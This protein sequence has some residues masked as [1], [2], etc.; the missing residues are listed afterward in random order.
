M[1]QRES[2]ELQRERTIQALCS[3]FAR[4]S[5]SIE[6]LDARLEQAQGA[7]SALELHALVSD[8][9]AF[10]ADTPVP[11]RMYAVAAPSDRADAQQI[12]TIFGEIK[13]TGSWIV[14][15]RLEV[16]V[17]FGSVLLDLTQASL[18]P[19]LTIIDASV[20]LGELKVIAPPG[21]RLESY[22]G[23]TL[24]GS[25]DH[26]AAPDDAL[27]ESAP[28]IR[29]TGSAVFGEV[30]VRTRVPRIKGSAK[31]WLNKLLGS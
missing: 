16:R 9:P 7:G 20:V 2:L 21:V 1:S 28:V 12:A 24:F 8:L 31:A 25:F 19:G 10:T 3:H 30:S 29:V 18:Q 26:K 13:R 17:L 11:N 5:L 22:A 15:E 14:P 4:D 27:P 23:M 6:D